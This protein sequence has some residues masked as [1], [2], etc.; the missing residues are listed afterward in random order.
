MDTIELGGRHF[1]YV[2]IRKRVKNLNLRLLSSNSFSVSVPFFATHAHIHRFITENQLWILVNS[3]KLSAPKNLENIQTI[4]ILGEMYT[5]HLIQSLRDK[6][7][8]NHKDRLIIIKSKHLTHIHLRLVIH[9]HFKPFAFKLIQKEI[10]YFHK[11]YDFDYGKVTLRAPKTRFGSC[12]SR[13]NLSFNWQIILFP[14]DKFQHIILH[15]LAHLTHHNH[16]SKFWQ[17]LGEYDPHC[18]QN[19]IWIRKEANKFLLI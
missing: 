18:S 3:T 10:D 14:Y 19:K 15:E 8:F 11:K 4:S 1:S 17:L 2:I 7:T 5:V 12:S 16:S 9:R 6:V 13:G